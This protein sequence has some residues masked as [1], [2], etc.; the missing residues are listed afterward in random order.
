ML[1]QSFRLNTD[2]RLVGA[3]DV[4]SR[5]AIAPVL[6]ADTVPFAKIVASLPRL[7]AHPDPLHQVFRRVVVDRHDLVAGGRIRE[8]AVGAD[9]LAGLLQAAEQQA[10][11]FDVEDALAG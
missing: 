7:A 3:S 10:G 6:P 1:F 4:V 5:P 8:R 9:V 11:R 2:L